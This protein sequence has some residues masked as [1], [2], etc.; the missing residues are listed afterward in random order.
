M[1]MSVKEKKIATTTTS[2]IKARKERAKP[3]I[4]FRRKVSQSQVQEKGK[5]AK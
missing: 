2:Q 3:K 5:K 4:Q 1:G